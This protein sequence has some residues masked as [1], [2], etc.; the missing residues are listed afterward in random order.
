MGKY[1]RKRKHGRIY[2]ALLIS[3]SVLILLVGSLCFFSAAWYVRTYGR[4]GFDSVLFTLTGGLS[5]VQSGLVESFLLGGALPAVL[6]TAVVSTLLFIRWKKVILHLK[7]YTI[8]VLPFRHG[9]AAVLILALSLGLTV[10]AAFNVELVDYIV[11]S[12]TETGLYEEHYKDPDKVQISF[13]EQKRNLLYIIL[14]SMET[15]YMSTEEGGALEYNLIPELYALAKQSGNYNFS[16]NETVGG[17]MQVSGASWTIGSMVAQT[18][19][20]PL[21][22]PE[23]VSDWQ[24][25][26]GKDGVFLP[27]ITCLTDI[28]DANGYNQA[29]MVGSDASFGGRRTYYNT[30][31]TDAI[32]DIYT[33][34]KD[35]IVPPKYW[36]GWWGFEDPYLFS[37]AKDV[38]T[39]MS[40]EG[41]PFAFTMLTVDTHH[42]GGFK[43]ALCG[44]T[45]EENYENVI[46]CSSRQVLSFLQWVMEQDWFENTTV[47][48]TGDHYSMDK[49][50]FTRNVDEGYT[51]HV[52]NC[53]INSA[54]EPVRT[55]NRQFCALDM[56]PS[57]LAAMGCT[58]EGERL[59]LGTNLFSPMP[60]LMEKMGYDA[61]NKELS[62][63]ADYYDR[64]YVSKPEE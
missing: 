21:K 30:H 38:L 58:I 24:N 47:I 48:V 6:L 22:T 25:G 33:A 28:L 42:I 64:F 15:S 61:F 56:F 7:N 35:G 57:T 44:D 43:C 8:P 45:Y 18:S 29:L 19:G 41:E 12:S 31:G 39:E 60:T 52:Y 10:H 17:F 63:A 14:E 40:Q 51:R 49:G 3:V 26:Y 1:E 27:G 53:F 13:P 54:A 2:S 16:H 50:Y 11:N 34:R 20:V 46:S 62:K 55:K 32:Y 5:G 36:N 9:T 37:Y 23:G 59:G 4:L